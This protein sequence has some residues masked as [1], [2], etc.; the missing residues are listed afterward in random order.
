M[1]FWEEFTFFVLNG[2]A[3]LLPFVV[4]YVVYLFITSHPKEGDE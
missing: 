3:V 1:N 4:A 2:A